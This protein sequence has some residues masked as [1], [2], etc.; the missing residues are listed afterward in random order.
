MEEIFAKI[1]Y[2]I[3]EKLWCSIRTLTDDVSESVSKT[4]LR[5]CY[6]RFDSD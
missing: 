3:R 4:R 6:N 1:N 5:V 2:L